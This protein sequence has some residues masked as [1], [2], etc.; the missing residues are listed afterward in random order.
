MP[1][2]QPRAIYD[3]KLAIPGYAG[4]LLRVR[5]CE[6]GTVADVMPNTDDAGALPRVFDED[7]AEFLGRSAAAVDVW[8]DQSGQGR[9]ATQTD[10]ERQ[11]F[12]R[13]ADGRLLLDF[14]HRRFLHLP[15]ATVPYGGAPFAILVKHGVIDNPVGG[16]VGSGTYGVQNL[17]NCVRR[18]GSQYVNYFWSNDLFTAEDTYAPGNVVA[19][20]FSDRNERAAVVNG[21]V[22]ATAYA[23]QRFSSPE[24]NTIGK[25][26]GE[27]EYLE[28]EL[29]FVHI[30]ERF[31][32]LAVSLETGEWSC[33][34]F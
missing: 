4:P 12:L 8:Y 24:N 11:P 23:R 30:T 5:H 20:T 7:I 18:N 15:P 10:P 22:S 26:Y 25:T 14:R 19:F 1:A 9:H 32:P 6:L 16:I 2:A 13:H 29:E 33:S 21:E 17:A 3:V 28:G 27:L 31:A 34:G